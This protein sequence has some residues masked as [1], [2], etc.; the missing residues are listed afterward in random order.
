MP[1][2][3]TFRNLNPR[4]EVRRRADALFDKLERFLD[5]AAEAHLI[6]TIEHH[7]A[8]CEL[9]VTSRGATH[10]ALETD[11]DLRT[12]LDRAF[13]GV[14]EQLRRNKEKRTQHE[15]GRERDDG[16]VADEG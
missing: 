9:I 15:R 10:K 4:D 1:L 11:G 5:P 2:E 14:E 3:V 16:F 13:H 12:S 8:I 7:E 6:V